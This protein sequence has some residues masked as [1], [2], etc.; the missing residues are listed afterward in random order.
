MKLRVEAS[1]IARRRLGSA[2]FRT[3][4][5]RGVGSVRVMVVVAAVGPDVSGSNLPQRS[6]RIHFRPLTM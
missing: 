2:G 4:M 6:Q 5:V 1:S 3:G